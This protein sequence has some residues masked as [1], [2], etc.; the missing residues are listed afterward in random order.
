M[1]LKMLTGRRRMRS[2]YLKMQRNA[3]WDARGGELC[4]GF[5]V[6]ESS[7]GWLKLGWVVRTVVLALVGCSQ[8]KEKTGCPPLA[9]G[10]PYSSF[11]HPCALAAVGAWEMARSTL[12]GCVIAKE[13]P[14]NFRQVLGHSSA[15]FLLLSVLFVGEP[16]SKMYTVS[17]MH[18]TPLDTQYSLLWG[19]VCPM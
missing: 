1:C 13:L 3:L 12:Q 18:D 19:F 10:G 7:S 5:V 14:R 6:D 16:P 15:C 17:P 11:R 8:W 9:P 2:L 4:V